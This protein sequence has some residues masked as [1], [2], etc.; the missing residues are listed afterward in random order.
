MRSP[1][2]VVYT[3]KS[4]DSQ[5]NQM[6]KLRN[7]IHHLNF[8]IKKVRDWLIFFHLSIYLW[9]HSI[10]LCRNFKVLFASF[11]SAISSEL[12]FHVVLAL[13]G[14]MS[15]G[16]SL[17]SNISLVSLGNLFQSILI[18]SDGRPSFRFSFLNNVFPVHFFG[19]FSVSLVILLVLVFWF[20]YC[21]CSLFQR[22][23]IMVESLLGIH[24]GCS[25]FSFL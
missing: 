11:I 1:P 2:S 14:E 12:S 7:D 20:F 8:R 25:F 3:K 15:P 17:W 5:Y 19:S 13:Q 23:L 22:S 24:L 6:Q 4:L 16:I 10:F 18:L 9:D 21:C